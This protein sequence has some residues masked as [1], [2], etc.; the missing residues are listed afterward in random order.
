MIKLSS[1]FG[2][3]Q[4]TLKGEGHELVACSFE[5]LILELYPVEPQR[6]Q[7]TLHKVHAYDNKEG[8]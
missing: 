5:K 2:I 7:N 8:R 4:Y 6:M 3:K 1:I